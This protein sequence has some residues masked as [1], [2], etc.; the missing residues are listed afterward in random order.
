MIKLIPLEVKTYSGYKA[1]EYPLSFMLDDD[2][3]K[4][5]EVTDRWYQGD[6]N[7]EYPVSHY[8]KVKTGEGSEC[9]LKHELDKDLWYLCKPEGEE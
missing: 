1:D 7:P 6:N 4:I 9:L 8:F 3:Y 2:E 5:A